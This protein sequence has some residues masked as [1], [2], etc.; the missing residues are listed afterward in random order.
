MKLI[1]RES[2]IRRC[3]LHDLPGAVPAYPDATEAGDED[4]RIER[5]IGGVLERQRDQAILS[6]GLSDR[7]RREERGQIRGPARRTGRE[8]RRHRVFEPDRTG[9]W[10]HAGDR[11]HPVVAWRAHA[12]DVHGV[13]GR[14][15]VSHR[16]RDLRLGARVRS[17]GDRDGAL[18]EPA[19]RSNDPQLLRGGPR[20]RVPRNAVA[21]DE[22]GARGAEVRVVDNVNHDGE[23]QAILEQL[24]RH[25]PAR[26]SA[27]DTRAA[28]AGSKPGP[29][30]T[31]NFNYHGSTLFWVR[32]G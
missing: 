27:A 1:R 26:R 4:R 11:E 16:R 9:A 10:L 6:F 7:L 13:S 18:D 28:T 15:L 2:G 30:E 21:R 20:G 24:D 8:R 29:E 25:R 32:S 17:V 23:R 22:D 5:H 14:E 19:R 31:G 12:R 3:V